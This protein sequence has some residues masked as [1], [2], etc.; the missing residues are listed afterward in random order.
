M[1]CVHVSRH[2]SWRPLYFTGLHIKFWYCKQQL[3]LHVRYMLYAYQHFQLDFWSL[4]RS[5]FPSAGGILL[6]SLCSCLPCIFNVSRLFCA[7]HLNCD[8]IEIDARN[9]YESLSE[10]VEV[11][12]KFYFKLMASF[13][14]SLWLLSHGT[15]SHKSIWS[16][17]HPDT[18]CNNLELKSWYHL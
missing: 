10:Y 1:F 16:Q 13:T 9:L 5:N 12:A 2:F 11:W 6:S 14:S 3:I 8:I 4:R 15:C 7:W 17:A 18:I